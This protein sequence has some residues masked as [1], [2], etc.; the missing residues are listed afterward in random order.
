MRT[1][2]PRTAEGLAALAPRLLRGYYLL[3]PGFMLFDFALHWN[4]RLSSLQN[5]PEIRV[6]YYLAC[7][8]VGCLYWRGG[9]TKAALAGL[10][11]CSVNVFLLVLS[12]MLPMWSLLDTVRVGQPAAS[13]YTPHFI[14][15][16]MISSVFFLTAFYSNPIIK[17]GKKYSQLS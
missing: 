2:T 17:R 15:N 5:F 16:L 13:P 10:I 3:T 8:G 1:T 14:V 7:I 12:V 6:F 9:A 4:V 11:E